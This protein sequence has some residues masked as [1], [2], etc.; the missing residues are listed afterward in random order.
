MQ[1]HAP[2]EEED[3]EYDEESAKASF[4]VPP[5]PPPEPM[6][7]AEGI[8]ENG[9]DTEEIEVPIENGEDMNSEKSGFGGENRKLMYGGIA[10]CV[11]VILAIVLGAGFGTGAFGKSSENPAPAPAPGDSAPP[12]TTTPDVP[13]V[14]SSTTE[15]VGAYNTYLETVSFDPDALQDPTS[16]EWTTVRYMANSD[17]AMLDPTDMS[18]ENQLRI[19]QRY[20]LLLL[21]FGSDRDSWTN[22]ENWLNENECTWHG[23]TC[24]PPVADVSQEGDARRHL[25]SETAVTVVDLESNGIIGRFPPDL[26]LIAGL[27]TLNLAGN[28]FSGTLPTSLSSMVSLSELV[29]SDNSFTGALS[30]T[31]FSTLT[32]LTTLDLAGNGLVGAIPDSIYTLTDLQLLGLD[33]NTLSGA[34]SPNVANLAS[35]VRFAAGG[36]N[37][38][39]GVP[40]EFASL[41]N[42]GTYTI[43]LGVSFCDDIISHQRV[44]LRLNVLQKSCGSMRMH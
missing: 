30:G 39:G 15:R 41:A 26:S 42:L 4:S 10:C 27:V 16:A 22:Q 18:L 34:I 44:Y 37:L 20:A 43:A 5:P 14:D 11:I 35:L 29:L 3:D 32:N 23:V 24:G 12:P 36:N 21:Y 13:D 1:E 6:S 40:T 9:E 33:N 2:I 31:D 8:P 25:Q 19:N 38:S 7:A 28:E 17:P